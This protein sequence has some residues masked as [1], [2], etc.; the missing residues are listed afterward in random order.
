MIGANPAGGK[1]APPAGEGEAQLVLAFDAPDAAAEVTRCRCAAP[2]RILSLEPCAG[3][4]YLDAQASRRR[5]KPMGTQHEMTL[6]ELLRRFPDDT[7][8]ERWFEAQRWP[9]GRFCPD[10]GSTN[11]AVVKT[12]RPMPYRCRD[13]RAHFSVR[14]GTTADSSA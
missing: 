14:K 2:G 3:E 9:Q 13:C 6:A 5:T 8:A 11:T 4:A 12:R 10:C 1:V 7:A